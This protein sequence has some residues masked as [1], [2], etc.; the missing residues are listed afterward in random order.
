LQTRQGLKTTLLVARKAGRSVENSGGWRG[1]GGGGKE[2]KK[3]GGKK[4]C[5]ARLDAGVGRVGRR[6]WVG[7]VKEKKGLVPDRKG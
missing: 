3:I 1:G 6:V 4:V 7:G 5:P 2:K